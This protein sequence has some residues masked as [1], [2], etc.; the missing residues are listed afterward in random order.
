[1]P[2]LKV[3]Y[4][5]ILPIRR[6]ICA[7]PLAFFVTSQKAVDAVASTL[8][9]LMKNMPNAPAKNKRRITVSFDER[10]LSQIEKAAELAGTDRVKIIN[11]ILA[12]WLMHEDGREIIEK[13][14]P[15]NFS[16]K[17]FK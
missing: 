15:P 13:N 5:V 4:S 17:P 8:L 10:L 1:M 2:L 12:R 11:A 14:T 16:R 6:L 7:N 3:F 9:F